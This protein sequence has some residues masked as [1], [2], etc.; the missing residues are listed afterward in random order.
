MKAKWQLRIG[1]GDPLPVSRVVQVD[2]R[3][4]CL[5]VEERPDGT[6]SVTYSRNLSPDAIPQ[7]WRLERIE[8]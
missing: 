1:D 4:R 8:S 6:F 3:K 5:Y 7:E 2:I